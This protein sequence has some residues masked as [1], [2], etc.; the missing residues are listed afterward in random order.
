MQSVAVSRFDEQDVGTV[1]VGGVLDDRVAGLSDIA[2]ENQLAARTV[3]LCFDLDDGRP[4]NVS[5][6]AKYTTHAIPRREGLIVICSLYQL[7]DFFSLPDRVKSLVT[8]ARLLA[9]LRFA[10]L[11][12][13]RVCQHHDKQ[14]R[15]CGR[16]EDRS[17]VTGA[18]EFR[19]QAGVIQVGVREQHEV[20]TADIE[21]ERTSV[22]SNRIA[23]ALEQPAIDQ[24]AR[25]GCFDQITRTGDFTGRSKK[26]NS[27]LCMCKP[28]RFA[29]VS[30]Q[31]YS[32]SVDARALLLTIRRQETV[33]VLTVVLPADLAICR[34]N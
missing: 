6:I 10:L 7:V 8:F 9:P 29:A 15:G 17:L 1:D 19:Q 31:L 28:A 24:K 26:G 27:H 33:R 3:I 2:R 5:G 13:G 20:E 12:V 32:P 34:R 14:V 4:Q 18:D 16:T 22:L 21:L 11:D 30:I 25:G 23:R